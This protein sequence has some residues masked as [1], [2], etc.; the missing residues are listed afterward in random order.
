MKKLLNSLRIK[1]AKWIM[2][3]GVGLPK[4]HHSKPKRAGRIVSIKAPAEYDPTPNKKGGRIIRIMPK[5][6]KKIKDAQE[7][8][9]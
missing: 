9:L 4:S 6:L 7:H 3:E 1:L 5:Q 8:E 2:P